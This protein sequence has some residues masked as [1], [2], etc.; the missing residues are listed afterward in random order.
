MEFK[1]TKGNWIVEKIFGTPKNG[2]GSLVYCQINTE[3]G[4]SI[5]FAGT[6]LH[7][8]KRKR[9]PEIE[10]EANAELIALAPEMLE[11]LRQVNSYFVVLQ[12]SCALTSPDERAWKLV[13]RIINKI[14]H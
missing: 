7:D 10:A 3:D 5:G 11:A 4:K 2:L 9:V 12:N 8:S 13:S 14:N 1:H 6:Y